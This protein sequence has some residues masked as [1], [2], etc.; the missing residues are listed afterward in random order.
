[1]PSLCLCC[2]GTGL[3]WRPRGEWP[4]PWCEGERHPTTAP[5]EI[6]VNTRPQTTKN[7]A[8]AWPVFANIFPGYDVPADLVGRVGDRIPLPTAPGRC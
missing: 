1:M 5:P 2:L 3:I 6:K 4:C 8:R 7:R